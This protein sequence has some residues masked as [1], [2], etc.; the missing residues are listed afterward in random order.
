MP[1]RRLPGY[2][3]GFWAEPGDYIT[4]DARSAPWYPGRYTLRVLEC[5]PN[6]A[7]HDPAY[8]AVDEHGVVRQICV[9]DKPRLAN[10]A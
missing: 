3:D 1:Q 9:A 7:P 2:P 4:A 6:E 5:W 10:R 8:L